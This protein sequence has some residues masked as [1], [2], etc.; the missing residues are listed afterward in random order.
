[1]PGGTRAVRH[2][3]WVSWSQADPKLREWVEANRQAIELFQQ[4]ADQSDA[5]N[6]AG[7]SVVNW[8]TL[9]CFLRPIRGRQATKWRLAGAWDCYR[10]VLRMATHTRR[11][12]SLRQRQDLD[13]YWDGFL[14]QRLDDL[15]GR[16]EDH[17]PPAS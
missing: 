14:Q 13:A 9:G 3:R 15:G 11:R 7:E 1:M 5:A 17:D 4:G 12:G 6:P 10:A 16:S 2:V 8:S